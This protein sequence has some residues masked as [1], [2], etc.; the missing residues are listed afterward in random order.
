MPLSGTERDGRSLERA[1]TR[2]RKSIEKEGR[3]ER[4][5][6]E[7]KREGG[8]T[9]WRAGGVSEGKRVSYSGSHV[10]PCG[11]GLVWMGLVMWNCNNVRN[12]LSAGFYLTQALCCSYLEM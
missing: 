4:G 12:L 9:R 2:E 8:R 7:G 3:G 5:R 1:G 10:D 6:R 11:S